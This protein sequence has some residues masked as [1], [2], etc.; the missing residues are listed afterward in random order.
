MSSYS[1][2][3]LWRWLKGFIMKYMPRMITCK[4]FESF[5]LDYTDG[6]LSARQRSQFELHIRLC[7][8]CRQYLQAYQRSVEVGRSV[9]LSSDTTVPDEV[10]D[11]LVKAILKARK[12]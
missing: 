12:L 7:R 5:I 9:F 8:E 6:G 2:N 11:D 10:P 1:K 3:R 4:E